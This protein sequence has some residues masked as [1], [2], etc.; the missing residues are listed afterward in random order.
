MMSKEDAD[1]A[2]A[3]HLA[4]LGYPALPPPVWGNPTSEFWRQSWDQLVGPEPPLGKTHDPATW[5]GNDDG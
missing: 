5:K 4:Q 3:N 2:F 1:K